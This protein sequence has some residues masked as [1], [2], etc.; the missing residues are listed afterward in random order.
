MDIKTI[1]SSAGKER[2]TIIISAQEQEKA[3]ETIEVE[4]YGIRKRD[5]LEL[6]YCYDST[7]KQVKRYPIPNIISV[8][9][10]NNC[11]SPKWVIEF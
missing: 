8:E 9:K 2:N 11:F 10:T 1:I 4:P 7:I 5:G 6:L 3:V